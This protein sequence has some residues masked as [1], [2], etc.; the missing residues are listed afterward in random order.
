[1]KYT[2]HVHCQPCPSLGKLSK[3]TRKG[4]GS[5]SL[6]PTQRMPTKCSLPICTHTVEIKNTSFNTF[7][8]ISGD[9]FVYCILKGF[10]SLKNYYIFW[11]HPFVTDW[12]FKA[13]KSKNHCFRSWCDGLVDKGSGCSCRGP[14]FG[15]QHPHGCP[16]LFVARVPG[17][18]CPLW[19]SVAP[20]IRVLLAH[21][22]TVIHSKNEP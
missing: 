3:E 19:A 5:S 11:K 8:V 7:I 14:T 6:P 2:T 15:S 13:I 20:G 17:I 16:Q 1:M 4:W 9:L 18:W 12:K 21:R 10:T 22:K